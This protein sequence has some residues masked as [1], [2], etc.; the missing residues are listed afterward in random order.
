MEVREKIKS[1]NQ[2]VNKSKAE[3]EDDKFVYSTSLW[4][5]MDNWMI[6]KKTS[7][8]LNLAEKKKKTKE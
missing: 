3:I 2:H 5:T 8:I 1:Y 4:N 7:S 6:F